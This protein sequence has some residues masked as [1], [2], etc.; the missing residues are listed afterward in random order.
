M[1]TMDMRLDIHRSDVASRATGS[2]RLGLF[3]AQTSAVIPA[4]WR[5]GTYMG[6]IHDELPPPEARASMVRV[7]TTGGK[8]EYID[9]ASV[10]AATRYINNNRETCREANVALLGREVFTTT[11]I[12]PGEELL[13]DYGAV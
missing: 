12:H 6:V 2:D 7:T 8:V 4:G 5:I 3:A 11:P 13:M 1:A 9:A 10:Q